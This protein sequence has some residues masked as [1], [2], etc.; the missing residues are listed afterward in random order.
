MSKGTP[1]VRYAE[2]ERESRHTRIHIVLD[3]DGGT[4]R[5]IS[6]GNAT[7]DHFL[8][9]FAIEAGV[10]LGVKAEADARIDDLH[11]L[12][13]VGALLG[14]AVR[15]ALE[16]S[17]PVTRYAS[18]GIPVADAWVTVALDL[19]GG[20]QCYGMPVIADTRIGQIS[21]AN[22][23]EFFQN[24]ARE[25]GMTLHLRLEAGQ[26]PHHVA[27]ACFKALGAAFRVAVAPASNGNSGGN[28][29][30]MS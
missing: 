19:M 26:N 10:N 25:C 1:G 13:D 11:V 28:K 27:E 6:T 15:Q 29:G 8:E 16:E 30:R 21:T 23:P 5:D 20:G 14:I 7:F 2:L 18:L 3:V 22:L 9:Q 17:D 24:F 4:R 12:E